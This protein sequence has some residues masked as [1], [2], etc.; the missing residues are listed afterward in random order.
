MVDDALLKSSGPRSG[1][2]IAMGVVTVRISNMFVTSYILILQP[3][4][5]FVMKTKA[6]TGYHSLFQ[7]SPTMG[8]GRC[9]FEHEFKM[10]VSLDKNKQSILRFRKTLF[11]C[12]ILSGKESNIPA[13][14]ELEFCTIHTL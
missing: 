1:G 10:F 11:V 3:S 6:S 8:G 14:Q 4:Y 2:G 12:T 7:S 9:L 5:I 13:H